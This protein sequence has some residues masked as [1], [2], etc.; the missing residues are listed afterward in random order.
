MRRRRAAQLAGFPMSHQAGAVRETPK[1]DQ[2][3]ATEAETAEYIADLLRQL[4][5]MAQSSGFVRL[6]FLLRETVEEAE[7][8]AAAG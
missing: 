2:R 1:E 8:A 4:E 3:L 6:A 5:L 7:K